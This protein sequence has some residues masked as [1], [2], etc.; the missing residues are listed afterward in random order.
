MGD[1][2]AEVIIPRL[3]SD[4]VEIFDSVANKELEKISV[5][6]DQRSCVTVMLVSGGYPETY[7][8]GKIITGLEH[9]SDSIP[10]HAGTSLKDGEIITNGGRVISVSSLGTNFVEALKTSYKNAEII[11]F[12]NKHYRR[13]IGFDL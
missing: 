2:E 4:L 10:F 13:D 1:P 6:F 3:K 7:E 8:K 12:D 11:R 9:V 5:E